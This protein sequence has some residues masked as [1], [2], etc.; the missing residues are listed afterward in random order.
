MTR[1]LLAALFIIYT[2]CLHC[3][4]LLVRK[5]RL[6]F[7]NISRIFTAFVSSRGYILFKNDENNSFLLDARLEDDGQNAET[8]AFD[9]TN[10]TKFL[11]YTSKNLNEPQELALCD[12]ES[13]MKSNFEPG[14]PVRLNKNRFN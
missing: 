4:F 8:F 14:N 9:P 7:A 6:G 1:R 2:I 3:M 11:L 10:D 13:L 12:P 5:L